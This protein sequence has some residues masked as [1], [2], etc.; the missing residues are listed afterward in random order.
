[1]SGGKRSE[2]VADRVRAELMEMLL[3]GEVKDP[4]VQGATVTHVHVTDDLQ[5]A[6]VYVRSFA[7]GPS[8]QEQVVEAFQKAGGFIRRNLGARLKLKYTPVLRFYWDDGADEAERIER[9]L[10]EVRAE[11]GWEP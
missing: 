5:L 6:K 1:M 8:N 7:A 2:K 9:V 4:R 10:Q 3:R 11:E